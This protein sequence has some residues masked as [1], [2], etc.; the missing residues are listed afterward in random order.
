MSNQMT[1]VVVAYVSDE[2]NLPLSYID[3]AFSGAMS[4]FTIP[5]SLTNL[6]GWIIYNPNATDVFVKFFDA[7]APVLGASVPVMIL[8]V[9]ALG[10]TVT[11]GSDIIINFATKFNFACVTAQDNLSVTLPASA[12][13]FQ[14]LFK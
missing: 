2:T 13:T 9:P 11:I 6:Y 1:R 10:S 7:T 14:V 4:T 12:I 3:P 8:Q 5:A